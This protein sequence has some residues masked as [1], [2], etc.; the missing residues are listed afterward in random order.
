MIRDCY[1]WI[2][3]KMAVPKQRQTSSRGKRRRGGHR[4]IKA[5]NLVKCSNCGQAIKAHQLCPY[6]G[7]YKGKEKI[8]MLTKIKNKKSK[9]EV[10]KE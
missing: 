3:I 10:V 9:K 6:C 5:I 8:D 7:Q 1:W 2:V 4:K